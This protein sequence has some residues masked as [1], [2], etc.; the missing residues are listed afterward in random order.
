MKILWP[1]K[2]DMI[3]LHVMQK[4]EHTTFLERLHNFFEEICV[5]GWFYTYISLVSI[6]LSSKSQISASS[7]PNQLCPHTVHLRSSDVETTKASLILRHWWPSSQRLPIRAWYELSITLGGFSLEIQTP[8]FQIDISHG[9]TTNLIFR[10]PRK[11]AVLVASA[12]FNNASYIGLAV[13]KDPRKAVV[14]TFMN[15]SP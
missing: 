9:F 2:H 1:F 11:V 4:T 6:F 12:S 7:E 8:S 10:Q 13:R 3:S 15:R 5:S 14:F